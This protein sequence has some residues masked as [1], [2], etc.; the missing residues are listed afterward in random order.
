MRRSV[1]AASIEAPA[2]AVELAIVRLRD[3]SGR[4]VGAGFLVGPREILTCAHV[5]TAALG[6]A[7][8]LAASQQ[9]E[10]RLDFPLV[11][12]TGIRTAKVTVWRPP[13]GEGPSD[14]AGLELTSP[15]PQGATPARLVATR[16]VWEHAFRVLGFPARLDDGVWATGRLRGRQA[17]GWVQLEAVRETGYRIERGFSGAPVWDEELEGVVGMAVAADAQAERRAAYLIP[18]SALLEA[19]PMLSARAIPPCPYRGLFAFRE[20]DAARFFGREEI[21]DRLVAQLTRSRLV[22]VVGPSGSG[23]S[24]L[25]FAGALPRVRQLGSWAIADLRPGKAASPLIA[26]ASALLPL[27]EPTMTEVD[28]LRELP[29]LASVLADRRLLEVV[30]RGLER[31]HADRLLLIVDQF[32]ELFVQEPAVAA[33][34]IDVLLQALA[35]QQ[36]RTAPALTVVLTLRADFLGRALEHPALARAL[37]DDVLVIGRMTR[38]QLQRVVEGPAAGEV[39]YEPGLVDRI[40]DDVGSEPGNLP[41]LEFALTLLW[42]HQVARTLRH[43]AYEALGEV[44]GALARY[45]ETVYSG[46]LPEAEQEAARHV[47]VQL[48][49]PG[50]ATDHLRRVAHRN[51]LDEERWRVAQRLAATRLVVTGRDPAGVET[52]E[53]V[54][55]ALISRW[56]RLREWVEADRAFRAWQERLRNTI[57]QWEDSG[58][59]DGA[60]LRGVALAEAERWLKQQPSDI[61]PTERTFVERSRS[62][63]ARTL[64]RLRGVAA[65]LAVLLLAA[66]G[67]GGV[68]WRQSDRAER[69]RA[70]AQRQGELATSRGLA[71]EADDKF[72]SQADLSILLSVAAFRIADTQ[73]A[74]SE[75]QNQLEERRDLKALLVGHTESATSSVFS[76]DGRTLAS[77]SADTTVRL[78]DVPHR[79]LIAK[80]EGHR[81][82]VNGVAFRPDGRTL[83]SASDDKTIRL[84]DVARRARSRSLKAG[85]R[86]GPVA[87]SPDGGTLAAGREDGTIRLWDT[88]HLEDIKTVKEIVSLKA[89]HGPVYDVAFSPDGHT[90]ASASEDK[91]VGL[92]DVAHRKLITRLKGHKGVVFS[93]AFSPDGHTFASAGD[94][95]AIRLWDVGRRQQ[96]ASLKG[97]ERAVDS[98]AFSHDGRILATGSE[99]NSIRLWNVAKRLPI[100]SLIGHTDSVVDVAFS[101]DDHTLASTSSDKSLM[102]WDVNHRDNLGYIEFAHDLAFSRDGRMLAAA[103]DDK[104]LMLW[105]VPHHHLTA[106]LEGHRGPVIGVAFS[107]DGRTLASASADKTIG[108]WDVARRARSRSLKAGAPALTVAF[109]PDGGTLAAGGEDGTIRLWDTR[110]LE[111]VKTVKEIASLPA[112]R[113]QVYDVAFSPD[114]RILASASQDKTIG[115]WDVAKRKRTAP[116]V[117]HTDQVYSVTFSPDGRTLASASADTTVALWDVAKR[118]RTAPLVG[119]TYG[120]TAV[121][122]SPDGRTLASASPDSVILWDVARHARISGY[123]ADQASTLTFS[124]DG[125]LL[126]A[127]DSPGA[128]ILRS[129]DIQ[130]WVRHLC[131]IAGRDLTKTEWDQFVPG[132]KY[133]T[134]CS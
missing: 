42:E 80:L 123:Y 60:L 110:H 107:P 8:G 105:D 16:E 124:P 18:T 116:L 45:A 102:L 71:L 115:L 122:F 64:R 109:S 6:D 93:V 94:D 47:F 61:S 101:P 41:L 67:L 84:W 30:D 29:K 10:V 38:E 77:A 106:K 97:H 33:E 21:S 57:R 129:V 55:E 114:G 44:D 103:S 59:D 54:H 98:V 46:E 37:Q 82:P 100:A 63:Q 20:E 83:A 117:G 76:P 14:I 92:W 32:E 70:R 73:E 48:V 51:E 96:I 62:L 118:K 72:T 22:A 7:S 126:A 81:G 39:A 25:V 9:V 74:R 35:A 131:G 53:V 15:P 85:A 78:W 40:L 1:G 128:I 31:V 28:R 56:D 86:A 88:H 27:L 12:P 2:S 49:R 119:H 43:A 113:D 26:L 50:E 65:V 5:V 4:I 79:H 34:F 127:Y 89:H 17:G 58:H 132:R 108:L 111:D 87:F 68:A 69:Q 3:A 104:T 121:A 112:H 52:V 75:L 91:T 13:G 11:D 120:V 130:E 90:L 95:E 125:R 36:V 134:V 66:S 23:K 133:Q 24:S 19:W 99:D